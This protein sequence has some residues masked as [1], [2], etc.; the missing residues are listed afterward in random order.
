MGLEKRFIF[1]NILCGFFGKA[2]P[3]EMKDE[4]PGIVPV[5]TNSSKQLVFGAEFLACRF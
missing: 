2:A 1:S 5:L 3:E 4:D